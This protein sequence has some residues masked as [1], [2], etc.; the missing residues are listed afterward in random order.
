MDEVSNEDREIVRETLA[1]VAER[2][3]IKHGR[4]I[5]EVKRLIREVVHTD[6]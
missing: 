6:Y 3:H 2:L 4:S 1:S 5:R